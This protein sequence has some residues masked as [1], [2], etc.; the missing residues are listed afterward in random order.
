MKPRNKKE[1]VGVI[2]NEVMREGWSADLNHIDVS[3]I[4][5][6][7]WVFSHSFDMRR[8]NGTISN[9]EVGNVK[10]MCGMFSQ[11]LFNGDLSQWNVSNVEDMNSMFY[12]SRFN[13]DISQWDVQGVKDM[14]YLFEH[15]YFD[16]V[17]EDWGVSEA[18]IT[19]GMFEDSAL[20]NRL[21]HEQNID[22]KVL[23]ADFKTIRA[24]WRKSILENTL[25]RSGTS[26][27]NQKV[28]L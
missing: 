18:C 6:L 3:E 2:R 7:S 9:W 17:L 24:L 25:E 23:D 10:N 14:V 5:D 27:V 4:D 12:A 28:R 16:H 21:A 20:F 22:P 8:F 11:S 13:G 1:L 15:S 19:T 26:G